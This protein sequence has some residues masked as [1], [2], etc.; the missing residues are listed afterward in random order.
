MIIIA[1]LISF[2]T[3]LFIFT[4]Y[5]AL[6]MN[7]SGWNLIVLLCQD[8][9]GMWQPVSWYLH[10][11]S[12]NDH[13]QE[14]FVLTHEANQVSHFGLRLTITLFWIIYIWGVDYCSEWMVTNQILQLMVVNSPDLDLLLEIKR[15]INLM[16]NT[17]NCKK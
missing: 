3:M 7:S 17:C 11:A 10:C 13:L 4:K 5:S 6:E 9:V 2:N 1:N 12:L 16:W 8:G 14:S 15:N